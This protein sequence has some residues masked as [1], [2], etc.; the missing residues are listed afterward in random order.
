[1]LAMQT[2]RIGAGSIYL[3]AE[4]SSARR[5]TWTTEKR[6]RD[7]AEF[8]APAEEGRPG[9]ASVGHLAAARDVACLAN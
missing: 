3:A 6:G 9:A 4:A 5:T 1:M 7:Y 2:R 8:V